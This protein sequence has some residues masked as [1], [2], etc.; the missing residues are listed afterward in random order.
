MEMILTEETD[1]FEDPHR[2]QVQVRNTFPSSH[3]NVTT[4][5]INNDSRWFFHACK[6]LK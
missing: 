3:V 1:R 4:Y 5:F 2:T 6:E